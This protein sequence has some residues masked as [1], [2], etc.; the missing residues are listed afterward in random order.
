MKTLEDNSVE[1]DIIDP[2]LNNDELINISNNNF[3]KLTEDDKNYIQN[4]ILELRTQ[5]EDYQY[6]LQV[7]A[8]VMDKLILFMKND[9]QF[10]GKDCRGLV[11]L[12]NDLLN[13][14]KNGV[15]N[16][17]NKTPRYLITNM[18]AQ[19]IYH[20]LLKRSGNGFEEALNHRELLNPIISVLERAQQRF[21][22]VENLIAQLNGQIEGIVDPDLD[23]KLE[24]A[25]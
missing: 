1:L 24:D 9:A 8:E 19:G 5:F 23:L 11:E 13:I 22:I 12:Y 21:A 20:F 15:L 18:R 2:S 16:Q 3:R 7:D 4:K 25:E 14:S 17:A 10:D 6:Q